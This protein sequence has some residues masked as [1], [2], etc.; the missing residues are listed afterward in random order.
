MVFDS[1]QVTRLEESFASIHENAENAKALRQA[2]TA[3]F[4]SLA[5][6]FQADPP[7]IR[8]AYKYYV[9]RIE[10]KVGDVDIVATIVNSL[11]NKEA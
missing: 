4:K 10:G 7:D 8:D 1:E 3:M 6:S 5:E 9:K 2:N 11:E